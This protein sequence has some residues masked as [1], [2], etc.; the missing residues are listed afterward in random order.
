MSGQAPDVMHFW[1]VQ[2]SSG[3]PLT[4]SLTQT[5]LHMTGAVLVKGSA[6]ATVTA[7]TNGV[8]GG[9][10]FASVGGTGP[11]STLLD[12]NFFPDDDTVTLRVDSADGSAVVVALTGSIACFD[13]VGDEE[14][15]DEDEEESDGD[16]EEG[17]IDAAAAEEDAVAEEKALASLKAAVK[18][19]R[20]GVVTAPAA[21]K[22]EPSAVVGKAAAA[23]SARKPF[24]AAAKEEDIDGEEGEGEGGGEGEDDDIDQEEF[25]ALLGDDEDDS[26]DEED[27]ESD[28]APPTKPA[29]G[30]RAR[31]DSAAAAPTAKKA[32]PAAAAAPAGSALTKAAAAAANKAAAN[33]RVE[34]TKASPASPAPSTDGFNA[35]PGTNGKVFFRDTLAGT[36]A[37]ARAGARISVG[38]VG[39]LKNGKTFDQNKQ[40]SFK[41]GTG[42]VIKGWDVGF[43]G[44]KVGG[45]RELIIHADYA[46]G[47]RGSPPVIPANSTLR[48]AVT[49]NRV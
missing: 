45:K 4:L 3:K 20:G 28:E 42:E 35:L 22:A 32:T 46:Y 2:L 29:A 39:T 36:G 43:A 21:A 16:G 41:L 7:T 5:E 47:A 1:G 34:P 15:E 40:F 18:G 38:Y 31:E 48:F 44:M 12:T 49:L 6:R 25:D 13:V 19:K 10:V 14:E 33:Q 37:L 27:E 17:P 9:V 30:K 26:E 23:V 11:S 24:A 8:P